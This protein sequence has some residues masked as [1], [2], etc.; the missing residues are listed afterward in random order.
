MLPDNIDKNET[1]TGG[2]QYKWLPCAWSSWTHFLARSNEAYK[3]IYNNKLKI[4]HLSKSNAIDIFS[5]IVL[6]FHPSI[7]S[8][9]FQKTYHIFL[10]WKGLN[11]DK[12]KFLFSL[13]MLQKKIYVE[14]E[15]K[16]NK[17][18]KGENKFL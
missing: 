7:T 12:N 15:K 4:R 5:T 6:W 17:G 10:E 18:Q 11:T 9:S 13:S 16:R 8:F 3:R 1:P 14:Y 2:L